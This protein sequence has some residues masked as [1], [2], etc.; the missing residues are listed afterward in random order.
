MVLI[1]VNTPTKSR[2]LG[3]GQASA[4]TVAA[5]ALSHCRCAPP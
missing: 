5:H 1:A 2:G 4:R 3:A